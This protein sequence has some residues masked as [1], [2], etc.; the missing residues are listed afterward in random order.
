MASTLA[1]HEAKSADW[2]SLGIEEICVTEADLRQCGADVDCLRKRQLRKQRTRSEPPG[3]R[4]RDNDGDTA[5]ATRCRSKEALRDP[6]KGLKNPE[7]TRERRE[8]DLTLNEPWLDAT[9]DPRPT[10]LRGRLTAEQRQANAARPNSGV[11]GRGRSASGGFRAGHRPP[12]ASRPSSAGSTSEASA[13][14]PCVTGVVSRIQPIESL[15]DFSPV[16]TKAQGV[17]LDEGPRFVWLALR[18]KT[19]KFRFYQRKVAE[20]LE[21]AYRDG[22]A[23]VP[24]IGLGRD[25]EDCIVHFSTDQGDRMVEVTHDGRRRDVERVEVQE[26]LCTASVY[27]TREDGFW[28]FVPEKE[29]LKQRAA[30]VAAGEESVVELRKVSLQNSVAPPKKLSPIKLA[31]EARSRDGWQSCT[32]PVA[33]E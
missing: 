33:L 21:S 13:A 8:G 18:A 24:L 17:R 16:A 22:R 30:D 29:A 27:V 32:R 11:S 4:T 9:L 6:W 28:R 2:R 25:V 7:C 31:D 12:S 15:D 23:S 26:D 3:A 10:A 19:G 14:R 1:A 20:R 5:F